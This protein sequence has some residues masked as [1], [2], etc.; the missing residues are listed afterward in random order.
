[1]SRQQLH[2]SLL[3]VDDNSGVLTAVELLM[4]NYFDE[5]HTTMRPEQLPALLSKHNPDVVLLDMNFRSSINTGN[6]GLY[7]LSETRRLCPKA[8]VVLFTAYA[9]VNLAVEGMKRGA[10]DFIVKPFENK[11]LVEVLTSAFNSGKKTASSTGDDASATNPRQMYWGTSASMRQLRAITEKVARTDANILI[12]GENGTGKELLAREIHRLSMR[13]SGPMVA[14]DMGAVSETLFESELFGYVQGA[15]TDAKADH[16][17][18]MERANH[19]TLFMD[20][21]G[22]LSYS[23]QAKLLRSLQQRQVVRVGSTEPISVDIRLVCATNRDLKDMAERGEFRDDLLYR[24]NT[25]HLH[26]PALRERSDDIPALARLFIDRYAKTYGKPTPE[27]MPDACAKLSCQQWQGNIRE[28]EHTVEKAVIL[29]DRPQ[30][31]A[32]DFDCSASTTTTMS[33]A[34]SVDTAQ[35][36]EEMERK[37]IKAAI[38]RSEGNM[39][40]AA[41]QLGITRQTLYNKMKRFGL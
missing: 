39:S 6:E 12:T 4:Q 5:V 7:W 31:Y 17:G 34:D 10:V 30:L 1:M 16:A 28:L 37:M 3:V 21:I 20:E 32:Q 15:F 41:E 23:L 2:G 38:D 13:A 27:L 33:N 22:N 35:T 40:L 14:V 9:D 19:G 18:K 36:L 29:A 26:L 24:I 25:I 11:R 8:R